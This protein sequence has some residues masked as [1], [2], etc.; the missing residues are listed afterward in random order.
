MPLIVFYH[1]LLVLGSDPDGKIFLFP[2]E[3]LD[4]FVIS[5]WLKETCGLGHFEFRDLNISLKNDF[6][7]KYNEILDRLLVIIDVNS[8]Q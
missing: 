7:Q 3:E 6:E 8:V 2:K 1:A 5:S 4:L